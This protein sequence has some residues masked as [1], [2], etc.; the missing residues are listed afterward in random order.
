MA[1]ATAPRLPPRGS[2]MVSRTVNLSAFDYT[3]V[4]N[5]VRRFRVVTTVVE[6]SNND[7]GINNYLVYMIFKL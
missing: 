5:A 7:I 1:M 3:F 2:Q 4:L 6:M